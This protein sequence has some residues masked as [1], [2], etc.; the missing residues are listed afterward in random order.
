M[1]EVNKFERTAV[2]TQHPLSAKK[3]VFTR[4]RDEQNGNT[5]TN[6][7]NPSQTVSGLNLGIVS[8]ARELILTKQAINNIGKVGS[9]CKLRFLSS[10]K[11]LV[12]LTR[13]EE[14]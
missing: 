5:Q 12:R 13:G 6:T 3:K 9:V 14:G 7:E 8:K 10:V 1:I 11:K 4:Q 2:K